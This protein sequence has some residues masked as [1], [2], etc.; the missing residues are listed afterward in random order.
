MRKVLLFVLCAAAIVSTAFAQQEKGTITGTITT[1]DNKPAAM[2]TVMVKGSKKNALTAD[3]GTFIFR[4]MQP[5]N[6]ELE[7]SLVGYETITSQV[8]VEAGKVTDVAKQLQLSDKQL[9]EVIVKSGLKNYKAGNTSSSLRLQAPLL[10]VPQ[11]IQ[12]VTNKVLADQQVISMSDGLVRNVSGTVRLEHWGDLYTNVSSRGSQVQAFRNGF[13]VVNSYWGPLTEDMSF[14]DHIEFVKGPAGF[15]LANGDP[16]GLYNVVTKKPTGQTKGQV[17]LTMGSYDLYRGT[18]DLDGKLSQDG[19]LL[20]RFNLMGQNKGSFRP[21]EYNNRYSIAPVLSYQLDEKTKLTLEYTLQHAKMSDVGSYYVY[22]TKGFGVLPYD[23]TTLPAGVEPTTIDDHSVF[24]NLQHQLNS[25]W[26]ITAQGSYFSYKQIGTSMWPA[27]VN[28]DGTML[29]SIGS[30]DAKSRMTL[31]Q[32]YVNGDVTTGV[33]RHRILGGIDAGNKEY[34]ADWGQSHLFDTAGAEFNSLDPNLGVPANGYPSFDHN[35]AT[36]EQRAEAIGGTINQR[37]TGVYVQDELGFLDNKVRLTLAG[38]YTYVK[39]SEW[40]GAAFSAK[41]FTPRVGLSVSVDKFTS[42]YGLY[43]QAFIPQAGKVANGSVK[44]I[45][46][47]NVEFGLKR[48]WANGRWNTTVAVYKI[49]KNHEL[50]ADPNSPPTSGLSIE[51]GQKQSQ[52]IEFDLRG[53]IVDGLN[54]TANYAFTESKVTKVAEGVTVVKKG[55]VVPGYAKHTA[56][57]W[58]N[59]RLQ[60][61]VLK[62][63]GISAG[64]TWLAGRETYWDASPDPA[65]KIPDY[66]K[67]DG[68]LSWEKDKIRI[69]V[70]VFNV[71]N[72]FIYSGS[73][74]SWLNAYYWQTET[75]RSA[76]LGISY[77]F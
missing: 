33:I 19:K 60:D 14:V 42:V 28:D 13:N 70:N 59:Y 71:F 32:A 15:M 25:Q 55:D 24:L 40:G 52:G 76:R 69:A 41:R 75:P 5:G 48:D 27:A 46:G 54:I 23:A 72:K 37:Y 50:T 31:M 17:E 56:N 34:F 62:G 65:Q 67:I 12:V 36:I 43:D 21:N 61:G 57:A 20:Y 6:Y 53:R 29:R 58:L 39:Q 18:V 3:D 10:E 63:I 47:S 74:Y 51:L 16:S 30:W 11:N 38:R 9:Q 8:A 7:I 26:K 73:Y 22:S 44:P 4:N 1:N 2:V 77:S 66:V 35:W 45:T 49:I 68:G 64:L